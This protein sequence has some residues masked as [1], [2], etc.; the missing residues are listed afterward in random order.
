MRKVNQEIKDPDTIESILSGST[1]CRLAMV[2]RGEPYLLPFNY[3]YKDH[4]LYIHSA[5][6]GRKITI[7]RHSPRVCFEIEDRVEIIEDEKACKWS[8][9]Y[10]S[11]IGYG[12]VS[13]VDDPAEK[14]TGLGVIMAQHG[15][16]H[17]TEFTDKEVQNMV[18]LKLKIFSVTGKQSSNWNKLVGTEH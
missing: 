2:D 14:K 16:P 17:L 7:L 11:V 12:E 9:L 3:G 10:R 5:R 13:I 4:S 6:E 18:I 15:A 8:T 1:I